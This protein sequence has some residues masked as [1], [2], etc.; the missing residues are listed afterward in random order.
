MKRLM[1]L[2]ELYESYMNIN[3]VFDT[4]NTQQLLDEL[5][6]AD[7]AALDFDVRGIDWRSYL[8][9]IHFPGLRRHVLREGGRP[10][11]IRRRA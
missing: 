2:A 11:E 4:S 10:R 7:R 9:D 5:H 8:Q 3:C 1:Y 6:E